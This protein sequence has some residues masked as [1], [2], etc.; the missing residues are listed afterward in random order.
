[1]HFLR[2][3]KSQTAVQKVEAVE[4]RLTEQSSTKPKEERRGLIGTALG[5]TGSVVTGGIL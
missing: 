2:T 3:D 4:A 1:M 5:V